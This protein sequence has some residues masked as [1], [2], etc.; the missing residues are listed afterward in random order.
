MQLP[1]SFKAALLRGAALQRTGGGPVGPRGGP[2]AAAGFS[3][4]E[5]P[6]ETGPPSPDFGACVGHCRAV[7]M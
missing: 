3:S 1:P 2:A 6:A 7:P 4:R 5:G